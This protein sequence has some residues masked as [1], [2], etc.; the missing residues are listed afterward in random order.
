VVSSQAKEYRVPV[1]IGATTP[2]IARTRSDYD[3]WSA[4][5]TLK[6]VAFGQ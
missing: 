2:V 1:P 6:R 5:L 3:L 4:P